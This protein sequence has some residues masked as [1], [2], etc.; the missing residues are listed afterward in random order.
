MAT[1]GGWTP[2][3]TTP[4]G[5]LTTG[6]AGTL[7]SP[8]TISKADLKTPITFGGQSTTIGDVLNQINAF[9]ADQLDAWQNQLISAGYLTPSDAGLPI[10]VNEATNALLR[11]A[12][13]LNADPATELT[14]WSDVQKKIAA[15]TPGQPTGSK[16]NPLDVIAVGNTVAQRL[17]G[18][19]LTSAE[20]DSIAKEMGAQAY[21]SDTSTAGATEQFLKSNDT[22]DVQSQS[23]LNVFEAIKS[24][25]ETDAQGSGP[26]APTGPLK[27]A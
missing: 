25:V 16:T 5:T 10:R 7:S 21:P 3:A 12:A 13:L 1:P 18:R 22:A 11:H 6:D 20:A 19:D 8:Y 14:K 23:L 4:G 9:S 26:R 2:G 27:V 24:K 15:R 17:M